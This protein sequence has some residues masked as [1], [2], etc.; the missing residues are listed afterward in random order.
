MGGGS[1][2]TANSSFNT[3]FVTCQPAHLIPSTNTAHPRRQLL[4]LTSTSTPRGIGFLGATVHSSEGE[5]G[6]G[7]E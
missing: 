2:Y 3:P 5:S 1:R 4:T 6:E 7:G